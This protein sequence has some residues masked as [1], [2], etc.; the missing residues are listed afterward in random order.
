MALMF[1]VP[2][3]VFSLHEHSRIYKGMIKIVDIHKMIMNFFPFNFLSRPAL[4]CAPA[5]WLTHQ[6]WKN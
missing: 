3:L 4:C 1:H 2:F 5:L 6:E